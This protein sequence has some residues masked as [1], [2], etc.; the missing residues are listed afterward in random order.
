MDLDVALDPLGTYCEPGAP[1]TC[2]AHPVPRT[3]TGS[4]AQLF[5]AMSGGVGVGPPSDDTDRTTVQSRI[6]RLLARCEETVG[7]EVAP[8]A[9]SAHAESLCRVDNPYCMGSGDTRPGARCGWF[10]EA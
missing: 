9:G 1:L 5:T 2:V 8:G 4:L 10:R 3:H 6:D 7:I